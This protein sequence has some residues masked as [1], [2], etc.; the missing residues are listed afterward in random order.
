MNVYPNISYTAKLLS[1]PTRGIVLESLMDGSSRPAT[2]LASLAGVSHP[3]MS[4]HL[5]KL[6]EGKMLAVEHQG[7][8][9][10][11]KLANEEVAELIEKLGTI[12]PPVHVQSLRQSDKLK[13]LKNGRTC[14]DHLAGEL[15]VKITEALLHKQLIIEK[16]KTYDVTPLGAEWFSLVGINTEQAQTTRRIFAKPCLDWSER[17]YHISGW[18]GAQIATLLF[19]K[20]WLTKAENSRAVSI[21]EEGASAL[22]E[23]LGIKLKTRQ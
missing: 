7:R 9:R 5:S 2:E 15:G 18:L 23:L 17:H 19:S 16:D 14:Y 6:V 8:H 20:G 13:R 4:S 3:T 12:A 11:Y 1:E 21:T 22:Q 10:Y